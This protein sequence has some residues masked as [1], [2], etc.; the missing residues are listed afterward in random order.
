MYHAPLYESRNQSSGRAVS[1]TP[2]I[3]LPVECF[4]ESTVPTSEEQ[5]SNKW[6]S[7]KTTARKSTSKTLPPQHNQVNP[8]MLDLPSAAKVTS[9]SVPSSKSDLN[10]DMKFE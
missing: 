2:N 1:L 6:S 7:D 9:T 4:R 5:N 8:K 10:A 3:P